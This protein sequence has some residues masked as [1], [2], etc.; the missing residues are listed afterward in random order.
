[1]L[2]YR[3]RIK[4]SS[5]PR[6]LKNCYY[7][8]LNQHRTEVVSYL[9]RRRPEILTVDGCAK[10][11]TDHVSIA[12]FEVARL[13]RY[14]D[15]DL[16]H[17]LLKVSVTSKMV[18]GERLVFVTGGAP[19]F[20]PHHRV[21]NLMLRTKRGNI[22]PPGSPQDGDAG[23]LLQAVGEGGIKDLKNHSFNHL[24]SI[25]RLCFKGG[26]CISKCIFRVAI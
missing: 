15:A 24:Q 9:Y 26:K 13:E 2:A 22:S 25:H 6:E 18:F 17:Q 12:E 5:F 11:A 16:Q 10:V 23:A 14:V 7:A 20:G 1:M 21:G 8:A 3:R 4:T 19:A